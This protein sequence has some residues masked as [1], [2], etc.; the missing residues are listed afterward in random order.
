[1]V[2]SGYVK[3]EYWFL[4]SVQISFMMLSF[5]CCFVARK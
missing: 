3:A 2:F 4:E 1:M 5:L